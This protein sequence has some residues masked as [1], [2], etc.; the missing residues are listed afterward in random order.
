[1]ARIEL[2]VSLFLP[3]ENTAGRVLAELAR[4]VE[5]H[6]R[7]RLGLRLFAS[8]EM[9]GAGDQF[10]LA[11]S[12]DADI[13]YLMHGTMPGRF[14]LT[15]LVALPF[16]SPDA[17]RGTAALLAALPHYL[18]DEHDGVHVLFLAANAPMAVHSRVPLRS[19]TDF[20]GR[21]IRVP[22]EVVAATLAALSAVP[23]PVLPLDVRDALKTGAVEGAAMTYQGAEFSRLGELVRF[24]T[25]LNANTVTFGLVMNPASYRRLPTDLRAVVDAVLGAP[26]GLRLGQALSADAEAGRAYMRQAGVEIIEPGPAERK[27]LNAALQ[28]VVAQ[29]IETLEARGL[30]ARDTYAALMS[31]AHRV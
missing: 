14:P 6:S 2:N 23:V 24:S 10:A 29:T 16:A 20:R 7:G 21:R 28:P 27:A 17:E 19:M 30:P 12:G 26:G 25:D 13:A 11:R 22:S 1:M 15:E 9:G 31:G 8:G 3:L 4:A 5:Q 18:A